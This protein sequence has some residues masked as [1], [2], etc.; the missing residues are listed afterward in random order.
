[1]AAVPGPWGA[2]VRSWQN[3]YP[4]GMLQPG[5]YGDNSINPNRLNYRYGFQG[6]E[7]D[8]EVRENPTTGTVGTG[9][10]Y[11]YGAR[12]YDS[13]LGRWWRVDAATKK[14][15][16]H[17]PYTYVA[18]SPIVHVEVGGDNWE[19]VGSAADI[20]TLTTSIS[21]MFSNQIIAQVDGAGM[22]RLHEVTLGGTA[23]AEI[24]PNSD[25]GKRYIERLGDTEKELYKQ[26][27]EITYD[28][29]FSVRTDISAPTGTAGRRILF[30]EYH[31][32][33]VVGFEIAI[34]DFDVGVM[35]LIDNGV[36]PGTAAAV[37]KS[38]LAHSIKEA[39]AQQILGMHDPTG[40]SG[41]GYVPS[42]DYANDQQAEVAG[43]RIR[44]Y[45]NAPHRLITF[46]GGRQVAR[47]TVYAQKKRGWWIFDI[48]VPDDYY[49][50]EIDQ[51]YASGAVD[52]IEVSKV[53]KS[54]A[55]ANSSN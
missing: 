21:N 38:Y 43:V 16:S 25:V 46:G 52:A 8:N 9:N 31:G 53:S 32:T 10:H 35:R 12:M 30:D 40:A 5:R 49:K 24:D 3:Y 15:P 13:R 55:D 39:Y 33:A 20:G 2:D 51:D 14:Y 36:P 27:S 44:N 37:A 23:G 50:I 54:E 45:N 11:D 1:M 41:F 42:H 17:S 48:F 6:Q 19:V 47:S 4:F 29:S 7:M 22:L 34:N 26:L 18:N 28:R